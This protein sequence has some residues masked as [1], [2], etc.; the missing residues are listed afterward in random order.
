MVERLSR[1]FSFFKVVARGTCGR[2][3]LGRRKEGEEE[4]EEEEEEEGLVWVRRCLAR[5]R[6]VCMGPS[7]SVFW[8]EQEG[9]NRGRRSRW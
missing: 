2:K 1:V 7:N 6:C 8:G 5:L 4:E 3:S 9:R